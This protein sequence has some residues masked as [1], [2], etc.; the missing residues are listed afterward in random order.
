MRTSNYEENNVEVKG[1]L[2]SESHDQLENLQQNSTSSTIINV[3]SESADLENSSFEYPEQEKERCG[4]CSCRENH[5]EF[6]NSHLSE[7][8]ENFYCNCDH[9]KSCCIFTGDFISPL[10]NNPKYQSEANQDLAF[11]LLKNSKPVR[12]VSIK[13]VQKTTC[14]SDSDIEIVGSN[15]TQPRLGLQRQ[16]KLSAI[17]KLIAT[18]TPP[19][20]KRFRTAKES[21]IGDVREPISTVIYSHFSKRGRKRKTSE[22]ENSGTKFSCTEFVDCGPGGTHQEEVDSK[23]CSSTS[24][25]KALQSTSKRKA[26]SDKNNENYHENTEVPNKKDMYDYRFDPQL[27]SSTSYYT[28]SSKTSVVATEEQQNTTNATTQNLLDSNKTIA[29]LCNIGNSCYL[30]SVVYTLRFAPLF[31]HKLH[32][33]IEDMATIYIKLNPT[34]HKSSSLGRNVSLWQGHSGRSWSSKDLASL[35]SITGNDSVPKNNRLVS[36]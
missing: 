6:V 17:R 13:T 10:L 35:G 24:D 9:F 36:F 12:P 2:Q 32:H 4:G 15:E 8:P 28:T 26:G 31:L 5:R 3:S 33:L 11:N 18:K 23:P 27:P 22:N 25:F 34:K 16:T 7:L 14:D 21:H 19:R 29:T 1:H 20:H 30:N